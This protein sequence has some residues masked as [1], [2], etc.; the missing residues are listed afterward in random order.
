MTVYDDLIDLKECIQDL[1][2]RLVLFK[3]HCNSDVQ[4]FNPHCPNWNK[5]ERDSLNKDCFMC[6]N[7]LKGSEQYVLE[8]LIDKV[9]KAIEN[10]DVD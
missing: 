6:G 1:Y 4:I 5:C 8:K 10:G 7:N 3:A 2:F 9:I